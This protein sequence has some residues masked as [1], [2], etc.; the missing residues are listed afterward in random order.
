MPQPP[1]ENITT[2]GAVTAIQQHTHCTESC[3]ILPSHHRLETFST[4]IVTVSCIPQQLPLPQ[5]SSPT[6]SRAFYNLE[7]DK[8]K[9][10]DGLKVEG[11]LCESEW[12]EVGSFA[13]AISP[14]LLKALTQSLVKFSLVWTHKTTTLAV[15]DTHVNLTFACSCSSL[16]WSKTIIPLGALHLEIKLWPLAHWYRYRRRQM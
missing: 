6:P 10:D 9:P 15:N 7:K 14:I 11:E 5:I 16:K 3:T 12:R 13:G 4:I 1:L 2:P 8:R